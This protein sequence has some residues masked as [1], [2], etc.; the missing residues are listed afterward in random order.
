[1]NNTKKGLWARPVK[2][3]FLE[4]GIFKLVLDLESVRKGGGEMGNK[5]KGFRGF[6]KETS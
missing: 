6:V 1:M 2:E 4:E 3:G 5:S